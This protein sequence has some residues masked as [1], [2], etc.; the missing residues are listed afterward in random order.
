MGQFEED[1]DI[2]RRGITTGNPWANAILEIIHQTLSNIIRTVEVQASESNHAGSPWDK[3]LS[4]AMF[5]LR[6]TYHWTLQATA[7]QL[8]LGRDVMLNVKFEAN[9]QLIKQRK[10]RRIHE[11]N[12]RENNKRIPHE[13]KIGDKVLYQNLIKSKC[14]ENPTLV[15]IQCNK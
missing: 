13:Y 15:P 6:V 2:T 8:V 4:A 3:I 12:A 11:N 1:Y 7:C 10:Q 14:G 5:A 9:W